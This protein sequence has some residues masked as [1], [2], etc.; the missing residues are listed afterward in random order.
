MCANERWSVR[1]LRDRMNGMLF[2]RTAI[3]K[4]PEE[5]VR[6]ELAQ[7]GK[8]QPTSPR[9]FFK[10]PYFLDFLDLK[11]GFSEKDLEIA[12]LAE[13]QSFLLELGAGFSYVDRQKR[14]QVGGRDYYID[15]RRCA[16]FSGITNQPVKLK[17]LPSQLV[18][19]P[20]AQSVGQ[21]L[22]IDSA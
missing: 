2:E 4:Q 9:L 5:V 10:D 21:D 18:V 15:L 6:Q 22:T 1:T 20:A 17:Q 14:I 19:E 12:L 8:R 7:L 3:A 11:G 13:I 16:T